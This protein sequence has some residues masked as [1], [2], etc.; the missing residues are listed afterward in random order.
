MSISTE[1][2]ICSLFISSTMF[3]PHLSL[4][5]VSLLC[6]LSC[7]NG[8]LIVIISNDQIKNK[9]QFDNTISKTIEK[10]NSIINRKKLLLLLPNIRNEI[11]FKRPLRWISNTIIK[12]TNIKGVEF[13]YLISTLLENK[14]LTTNET[15][16]SSTSTLKKE[17]V[18]C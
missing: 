7:V 4:S 14:T 16:D 18:I 13:L 15:K 1:I 6:P 9:W 5:L 12:K 8:L 17:M 2:K 10:Y 3:L 11:V